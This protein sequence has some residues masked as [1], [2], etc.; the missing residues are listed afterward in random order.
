MAERFRNEF[1]RFFK[2]R[3]GRGFGRVSM[4]VHFVLQFSFHGTEADL[5]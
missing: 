1:L 3:S 2:S 4:L 5:G